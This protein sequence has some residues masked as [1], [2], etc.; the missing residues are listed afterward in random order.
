MPKN[1]VLLSDGTGNSSAKLLKTNV[2]R[3]YEA[4][5]LDDPNEQL[6]CYDDGVGT[7]SFKPL[8]LLGGALGVGLKRNVL[9]LY[10]FLCEHYDEGDRIYA[11][12]FSRG[13]FTIRVLVGLISTQGIIKTRATSPMAEAYPHGDPQAAAAAA[14]DMRP[15]VRV[16]PEV[17]GAEL[18]RLSRWAY[19]DF[20]RKFNQTGL[21]VDIARAVRDRLIRATL[22]RGLPTYDKQLNHPPPTIAFVGVWDTVDAYGLPVDELTDGIN[23]WVWPLSAP[24]LKLSDKVARA[25][26]VVAI[27]DERNT[28]HP[29]LWD[30]VLE[31]QNA[32]HVDDE[33]VS[34]VWF[35][36]MHSNV[37][38]GYPDDALSYLSLKWMAERAVK[39]QLKFVPHLLEHHAAKA[40][41][42]GRIYDSRGGLK[43]Y[44]RYNPR[45]IEWLT[46]GQVHEGAFGDWAK[47]SPTVTI[48]RP[49]IHESVLARIAAAPEAYAPI[50][51]PAHYAIVREDGSIIDGDINPYEDPSAR[52]DRVRAQE[53]VWN[54]VWLRRGFYFATVLA[55]LVFLLHPFRG[56]AATEI[57]PAERTL[58]SRGLE[59]L[60]SVIGYVPDRWV[61]Y[62]SAHPTRFLVYLAII[63]VLMRVSSR[64]QVDICNGMRKVWSE[65]IPP[66]RDALAL[67]QPPGW[68]ERF[69]LH[70]YYQGSLAVLRH[71][72]LPTAF[73]LF[74]LVLVAALA[75][76]LLNRALFEA[77]NGLG[78]LCTSQIAVP[79]AVNEPKEIR[80]PTNSFCY[81]TGVKM[82]KGARYKLSPVVHGWDADIPVNSPAGFT[83]SSPGLTSSQ[84]AIFTLA[85]P[86]RRVWAVDWYVP[87]ARVG[88]R[89]F[90][91]HP[92]ETANNEL[93]ARFC[94]ELFLF[95]N[96]AIA[97]IGPGGVGWSNYY[98]NN[99]APPDAGG[100]RS[101]V[102]VTITKLTDGIPCN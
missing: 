73:G 79:L 55:T 90:S 39:C 87:I 92:L 96:D 19:R 13:A 94:G 88:G 44:Y 33:R 17:F 24:D 78:M 100:R 97:P 32:T 53:R 25:C 81:P 101:E 98:S 9:R 52:T 6:A 34:Q 7:S 62:Y 71:Q 45:R 18:A 85:A 1:I 75:F 23:K 59:L 77:A 50:I 70:P 49:K 4:L 82:Q 8:Q 22:E 58:V 65:V 43:S 12:G 10:R 74:A 99:V 35:A 56:V 40:D 83:R 60:N 80:F 31:P 54:L 46:N 76:G 93:A 66:G 37:G 61:N 102:I 47:S 86:F 69:R 20:R 48:G 68:L 38:G 14:V 84:R 51:F 42:F 89:G 63:L 11:F 36:G 16:H 91:Q 28:F 29:V 15:A 26:H 3:I 72:I 5:D 64:L 57:T 27:D 30:E 95:V 2:W 67:R 41:P 21:L